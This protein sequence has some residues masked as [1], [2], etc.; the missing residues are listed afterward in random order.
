[1]AS[2]PALL[3]PTMYTLP[4]L[5]MGAL[6]DAMGAR[7]CVIENAFGQNFRI[8]IQLH[9]QAAPATAV[10]AYTGYGFPLRALSTSMTMW[11]ALE[12]VLQHSIKANR[13]ACVRA[14]RTLCTTLHEHRTATRRVPGQEGQNLGIRPD[15]SQ[16]RGSVPIAARPSMRC[17]LLANCA[18]ATARAQRTI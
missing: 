8:L 14:H 12:S 16:T 1:M 18:L 9:L 3:K 10:P 15:F 13:T 7:A 2:G 6:E 11:A 5:A 17:A 4:L